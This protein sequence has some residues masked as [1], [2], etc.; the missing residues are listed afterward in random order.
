MATNLNNKEVDSEISSGAV[1][2][3]LENYKG[4]HHQ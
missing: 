3:D 2:E 4:V 1:E